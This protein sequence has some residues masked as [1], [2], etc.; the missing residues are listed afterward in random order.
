MIISS[1]A[2]RRIFWAV[3]IESKG[4]LGAETTFDFKYIPEL[5]KRTQ[6]EDLDE[7]GLKQSGVERRNLQVFVIGCGLLGVCAY[8]SLR[9][10]SSIVKA[11]WSWI[12]G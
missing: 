3:I 7:G 10:T 12:F 4:G 8:L 6:M 2:L 5:S 1:Q 9:V 11:I